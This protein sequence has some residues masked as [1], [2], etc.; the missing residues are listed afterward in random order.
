MEE[1]ENMRPFD[2]SLDSHDLCQIAEEWFESDRRN[3]SVILLTH[4]DRTEEFNGV[5]LSEDEDVIVRFLLMIIGKNPR[6]LE[7]MMFLV[8]RTG[9]LNLEDMDDDDK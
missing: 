7:K 8:A 3:R 9:T 1:R 2:V 6:L 5:G 4:D